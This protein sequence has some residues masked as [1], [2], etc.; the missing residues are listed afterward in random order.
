MEALGSL[1]AQDSSRDALLPVQ[2]K[3]YLPPFK[4]FSQVL[5]TAM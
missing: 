1:S 3:P 5:V 2:N 4:A